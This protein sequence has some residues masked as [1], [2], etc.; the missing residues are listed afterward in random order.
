MISA[1]LLGTGL[2]C[3]SQSTRVVL[4]RVECAPGIASSLCGR[5]FTTARPD[6]WDRVTQK[7]VG[8]RP[9]YPVYALARDNGGCH[10]QIT[11]DTVVL[12]ASVAKHV[13]YRTENAPTLTYI[14]SDDR[15]LSGR[16][17]LEIRTLA[18]VGPFTPRSTHCS[19]NE[20]RTYYPQLTATAVLIIRSLR[21]N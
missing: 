12:A 16:R 9:P 20:E 19:A 14:R 2:A 1:L 8:V 10:L 11:P 17:D 13:V 21:V 4:G 15:R 5:E 18:W 6:G 3:G 7:T